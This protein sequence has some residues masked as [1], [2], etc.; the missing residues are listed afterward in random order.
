M[1]NL[2]PELV[3][4]ARLDGESLD[5]LIEAIWPTAYRVAFG[6][7]RD[8]GLA[9]DAAQ[10]ACAAIVRG[11]PGLKHAGAFRAWSYKVI[12][13][14]ALT[15]ARQRPRTQT[16][17]S[18]AESTVSFDRSDAL[19]LYHALA[20]LPPAQRA[21]V[22]LHYYAGLNSREIAAAIGVPAPTIRFH[23][24]L[25]RRTLRQA[26]TEQATRVVQNSREV[27]SDAR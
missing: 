10:E 16:L 8:A 5:R 22:I 17:D 12:V 13:N 9:E 21:A 26:L 14:Q 11:L 18:A 24:M 4:R 27:T 15:A 6:I 1:D 20:L 23:L 25:A 2:D 19:D 7:L 3:A